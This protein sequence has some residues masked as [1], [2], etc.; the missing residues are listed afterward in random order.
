M[1]RPPAEESSFSIEYQIRNEKGLN[2]KVCQKAFVL[3]HGF[4]KRRL[5]FLRKKMPVGS[6]VPELDRRG[7]HC[8][9]PLKVSEELHQ[10][11]RE[12]IMSFPARQSHYS[13]HNNPGRLYLS[14]DLSIARMY[15]M[16]LGKY[17]PTYV[18]HMERKR[19][20]LI[21]HQLADSEEIKPLVSEHYYHD[22]FVNEFNI[23]FGFPRS[24]TC[25]TCD[26]L[27]VKI[28]TAENEEDKTELEKELQDHLALAE[29]GYQSLR[30]DCKRSKTSWSQAATTGLTQSDNTQLQS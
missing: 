23:H 19:E 12:H 20:A 8:N 7:K 9:R 25:D 22:I 28:D 14:P 24:D 16:F 11:V 27:K 2:Q 15:Q 3:I 5:E 26:S 17:D 29:Q 6:A 18:A 10:K 1:G 13:R 4:G 21:N 30:K